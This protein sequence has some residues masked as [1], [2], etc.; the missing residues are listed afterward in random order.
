MPD[1]IFHTQERP[2]VLFL[3]ERNDAVGLIAEALF[4]AAVGSSAR[5]F[6][7][8]TDPAD[9]ANPFALALLTQANVDSRGLWPKHWDGFYEHRSPKIDALVLLDTPAAVHVPHAWPGNPARYYWH[10][11]HP[12]LIGLDRQQVAWRVL[13]NLRPRVRKLARR[14]THDCHPLTPFRNS[15]TGHAVTSE[16]RT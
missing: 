11:P 6:S 12:S 15:P 1:S 13:T 14:Y 4:N 9:H 2:N 8:G 10:F 16:R 5:A 7:A 3:C